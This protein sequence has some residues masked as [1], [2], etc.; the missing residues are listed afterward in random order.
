MIGLEPVTALSLSGISPE[1]VLVLKRLYIS[2]QSV[3]K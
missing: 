3:G 1:T 2:A